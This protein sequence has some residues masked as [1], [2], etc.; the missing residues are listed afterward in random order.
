M[1]IL[2]ADDHALIREG[3]RHIL[4]GL[5]EEVV[6]L[7]AADCP[8]TLRLAEQHRDEIDLILLDL[9]MPGMSGFSA[10]HELR[11]RYPAIPVVVLSGHDD[12]SDVLR[13]LDAGA[14]GYIPKSSGSEVM[15]NA[16]RLVFAG[17]VYIPPQ[18]LAHEPAGTAPG[19]EIWQPAVKEN[20]ADYGPSPADL[21]LT[22]RQAQVLAR[23]VQGKPNKIICRELGLTEGTVKIHVTAILKT[24]NVSSR[25]QAVIAVS[26]L[27][28]RLNHFA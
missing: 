8:T 26:R 13:A 24:L 17:G 28:L 25:T 5:D 20:A 23:I 21:G 4:D 11:Q 16:L 10:L 9:F 2:V 27:G 7:E 6:F 15:V 18:V 22:H 12:R 3:L 1:K 19:A 14:M